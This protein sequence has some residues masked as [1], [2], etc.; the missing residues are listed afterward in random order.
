M[1]RILLDVGNEQVLSRLFDDDELEQVLAIVSSLGSLVNRF[2]SGLRVSLLPRVSWRES[3]AGTDRLYIASDRAGSALCAG[4]QATATLDSHRVIS[5]RELLLGRG[6]LRR[7]RVQGSG[8][9]S[10]YQGL[11]ACPECIQGKSLSRA[12]PLYLVSAETNVARRWQGI[13]TDRNQDT[14]VGMALDALLRPWEGMVL[15][16][17]FSELGALRFDKDMRSIT[18]FLSSQSSLPVRDKFTRL[19][20]ISY[21]L[22]LDTVSTPPSLQ[23]NRGR[24]RQLTR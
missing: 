6:Q 11:G 8:A 2:Q 7:S 3:Q 23:R 9:P 19:Q 22:N 21:V 15:G 5:R 16:M 14:Y 10:L 20:Q 17:R 24:R 18:T 12:I 4:D 13:F 1:D